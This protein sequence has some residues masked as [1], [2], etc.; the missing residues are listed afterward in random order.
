MCGFILDV[1]LTRLHVM[2]STLPMLLIVNIKTV[3]LSLKLTQASSPFRMLICA[4]ICT[5]YNK[6]FTAVNFSSKLTSS[7]GPRRKSRT[8]S[9]DLQSGMIFKSDRPVMK[10]SCGISLKTAVNSSQF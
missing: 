9:V 2:Q 5:L 10:P 1:I 4:R 6:T 7:F 3:N 8:Q